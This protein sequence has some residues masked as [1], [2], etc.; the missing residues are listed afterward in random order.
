MDILDIWNF[1]KEVQWLAVVNTGA[2]VVL[3]WLTLS[4]TRYTKVM[5]EE[6]K[7]T[8]EQSIEP[9]VVVRLEA[10][11]RYRNLICLVI[12][13]VGK[14]IAYNLDISEKDNPSIS[15]NGKTFHLNDLS[16]LR[17]K[18]LKAGER[19][20]HLL[21]Q[22]GSLPKD[23]WIFTA[24]AEDINRKVYEHTTFTNTNAYM[25][26]GTL[27]EKDLGDVARSLEKIDQK[28]GSWSS[29][30]SSRRI[31]VNVYSQDDRDREKKEWE[32][33][34]EEMRTANEQK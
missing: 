22:Y 23:L 13:N 9:H 32:E 34:R 33:Y 4:L 25:G 17:L 31:N 7:K 16:F 11:H 12:E 20:E 19:I 14:G 2:T 5:A 1:L 27:E 15:D 30:S 28:I 8:R 18:T 3:A 29:S 24:K 26:L 6:A 21:T 10:H